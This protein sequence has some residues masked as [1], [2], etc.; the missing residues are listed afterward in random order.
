MGGITTAKR[1][2]AWNGNSC[3]RYLL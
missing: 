1:V 2:R 3:R